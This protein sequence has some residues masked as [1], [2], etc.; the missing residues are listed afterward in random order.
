[1][2]LR[3]LFS[4]LGFDRFVVALHTVQPAIQVE[5]GAIV[6]EHGPNACFAGQGSTGWNDVTA[7]RQT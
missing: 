4:T 1:V 3:I 6:G 2:R 7:G 5:I